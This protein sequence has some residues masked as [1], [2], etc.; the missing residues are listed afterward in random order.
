[1]SLPRPPAG[2]QQPDDAGQHRHQTAGR[3]GRKGHQDPRQHGSIACERLGP[4][5]PLLLSELEHPAF[6]HEQPRPQENDQPGIVRGARPHPEKQMHPAKDRQEGD[7]KRGPGKTRHTALCPHLA[8]HHMSDERT[9]SQQAHAAANVEAGGEKGAHGHAVKPQHACRGSHRYQC[10][11]EDQ[12]PRHRPSQPLVHTATPPAQSPTEHGQINQRQ[13]CERNAPG[14]R[15]HQ[16][17]IAQQTQNHEV[18]GHQPHGS[19]AQHRR[20]PFQGFVTQF[21][22]AP[23][24]RQAECERPQRYRHDGVAPHPVPV[25]RDIGRERRADNSHQQACDREQVGGEQRLDV[26]PPQRWAPCHRLLRHRC[27]LTRHDLPIH[28]CR[29]R[30]GLCGNGAAAR[31]RGGKRRRHRPTWLQRRDRRRRVRSRT[32]RLELTDHGPLPPK[33]SIGLGPAQEPIPTSDDGLGLQLSHC[34]L[35]NRVP[36][37][38]HLRLVYAASRL[39]RPYQSEL[40]DIPSGYLATRADARLMTL[41]LRP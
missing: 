3:R 9:G 14:R 17:I 8:R 39:K 32:P 24:L 5:R 33:H 29:R 34:T 25:P 22:P 26:L 1:M 21:E 31:P 28:H 27:L 4:V 37:T 6:P 10:V 40:G 19:P 7:R 30:R 35:P 13:D 12:R 20:R 18:D 16:G 41:G 36:K 11:D 23:Q 15:R 38:R 2:L